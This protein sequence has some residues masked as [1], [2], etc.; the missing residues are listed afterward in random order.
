MISYSTISAS[1]TCSSTWIYTISVSAAKMT[2]TFSV[3][4]TF[5]TTTM[6]Q[7][8][9]SVSNWTGAYRSTQC[10]VAICIYTA[11]IADTTLTLI[12]F[13]FIIILSSLIS[14]IIDFGHCA[15]THNS[16]FCAHEHSICASLLLTFE[17]KRE[18]RRI[19][20]TFILRCALQF[21]TS[22]LCCQSQSKSFFVCLFALFRNDYVCIQIIHLRLVK[23][24]AKS[25]LCDSYFVLYVI[26]FYV[27]L[28]VYNYH[29]S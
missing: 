16:F 12:Q 22:G 10:F 17:A 3:I 11:R 20:I 24:C 19:K 15:F 28:C 9:S 5:T 4:K 13:R 29:F 25:T 23:C 1:T 6:Y 8:I 21:A 7:W 26:V 27:Y 2:G 14:W 18:I